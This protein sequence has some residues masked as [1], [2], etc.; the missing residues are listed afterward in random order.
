MRNYIAKQRITRKLQ[1]YL[2]SLSCRK[3]KKPR[4]SWHKDDFS[5]WTSSSSKQCGGLDSRHWRLIIALVIIEKLPALINVWLEVGIRTNN[6]LRYVNVTKL[7]QTRGKKPLSGL[8]AIVLKAPLLSGGKFK[9]LLKAIGEI[10]LCNIWQKKITS[11]DKVRLEILIKNH[12]PKKK[13]KSFK[14]EHYENWQRL[15]TPMLPS[16]T[17]EDFAR[18]IC[19]QHM[20]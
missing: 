20:T 9:Q 7:H 2:L 4:E 3:G 13:M 18:S 15:L 10:Y 5:C 11:I 12:K 6:T 14:R 1:K 16:V 8:N 17:K 19:Q